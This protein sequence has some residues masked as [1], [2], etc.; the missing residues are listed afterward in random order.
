[1]YTGALPCGALQLIKRTL[2]LIV[3]QTGNLTNESKIEVP[4]LLWPSESTYPQK[5]HDVRKRNG[6]PVV[7]CKTRIIQYVPMHRPNLQPEYEDFSHDFCL[8]LTISARLAAPNKRLSYCNT[9]T[10]HSRSLAPILRW[11]IILK[12]R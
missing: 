8:F 7:R 2:K 9:D 4:L 6:S 10:T 5:P 12:P 1:M 3:Q 11:P